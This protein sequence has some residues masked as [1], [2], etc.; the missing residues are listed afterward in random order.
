MSD[1][2]GPIEE[3]H[4]EAMNELG[5]VLADIFKGYGFALL[6]FDFNQSGRMNYL[7]NAA[8]PE[9]LAAM[10]EFIANAEGRGHRAPRRRS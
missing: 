2:H 7:S 10:K 4:R 3:R 1:T 6:V 5:H 9:M 8:R